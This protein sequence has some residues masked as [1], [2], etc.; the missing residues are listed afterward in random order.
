MFK[1][2]KNIQIGVLCLS[3]AVL[4]GVSFQNYKIAQI[5]RINEISSNSYINTEKVSPKDLFLESWLLVK[6]SYAEPHLNDQNWHRWKRRYVNKI[7]DIDDAYVAIN[8]M[9]ASLDDP[10][11]RLLSKEEFL[12]QSNSIES[13]MYGIGVNIAS[14]AGKIYI[15]NVIKGSPADLSGLKQGDMLVSVD[16]HQIKGKSIFQVAQ[17][18]KGA[19]NEVVTLVISRDGNKLTKK[20]KRAEIKVKTVECAKLDKDTGYIH[21][22]SFIG[23]DTPLE[24]INAMNKVKDTKGLILD[25]RGNTGGLF[26][27]AVFVSNLFLKSGDIVSVIGRDGLSSSYRVQRGEF[28][29][30][31]PLVVLVDGDSASA[32]EIVSGALKDNNR[33]KIVGTKTFGKGVVQKIYAL[34]NQMGMN[35]TIAKY[36]TPSGRDINEKGIEP[37]YE[38]TFTRDDVNKNFDRQLEFAKNLIAKEIK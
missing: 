36:L 32:S 35:L 8:T 15:V 28:V 38:V 22:I 2:I 11:S 17:Y 5:E 1:K 34:P 6:Q 21:I 4:F 24:F 23:N 27:N 10:Y 37:D 20:I 25:L 30:E 12:E 13:K 26:Q 33:A 3:L 31:K 29:Y 16:N 9:L 14:V 7:T 19:L 18:I